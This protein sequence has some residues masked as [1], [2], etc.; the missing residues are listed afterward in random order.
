MALRGSKVENSVD[1]PLVD[2]RLR[3]ISTTLKGGMVGDAHPT[4][5]IL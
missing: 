2:Q 3:I 1:L 4:F 5:E